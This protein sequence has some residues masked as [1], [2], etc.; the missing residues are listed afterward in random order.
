MCNLAPLSLLYWFANNTAGPHLATCQPCLYNYTIGNGIGGDDPFPFIITTIT[1]TQSAPVCLICSNTTFNIWWWDNF[2]GTI[3]SPI[4]ATPYML[5][6]TSPV[7]IFIIGTFVTCST[8]VGDNSAS[9]IGECTIELFILMGT[10][11]FSSHSGCSSSSGPSGC[12]L[13]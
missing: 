5:C 4:P 2:E 12:D 13:C 9:S 7:A 11:T 3:P 6:V 8:G 1:I 10:T